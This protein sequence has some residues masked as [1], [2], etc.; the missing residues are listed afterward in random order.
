[1]EKFI[2]ST[3]IRRRVLVTDDEVINREMLKMILSRDYDVDCACNG[4][5]A[6]NMLRQGSY[7]LLLLDLLMP[8]LDGFGVIER[9]AHD[10]QL[11][12]VPIIVMTSEKSALRFP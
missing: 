10:E 5:E 12:N 1:M 4:E 3:E 6:L 8:V 9:C 2:E 7:S 11:K